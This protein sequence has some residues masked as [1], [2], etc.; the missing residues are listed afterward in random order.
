M[1][2]TKKISRHNYYALLWHALFLALAKN[3]MDVDTIIPAMMID[4]GGT[5][6]HIGLL[7]AIMLGGSHLSQLFFAPFIN[8]R[9]MKKGCLLLGINA[10]IFA[11]TCLAFLFFLSSWITGSFLIIM[12]FLFISVFSTSGGFAN[13]GYTDIL[14]KS[15]LPESRKAFFSVKQV[16]VSTGLFASAYFASRALTLN[17]YPN[18]YA[19]LFVIATVMLTIASAGFWRLKEIKISKHEI[20]EYKNFILVILHEIRS[21]KKLAYYLLVTNTQGVSLA[22]MP[23]LILYAKDVLNATGS[24]IGNYLIFKVIGGILVG[25]LLFY[26]SRKVKYQ[27]LLYLT[28]MLAFIIPLFVLILPGHFSLNLSFLAGGI[29]FTLHTIAVSGVLLEVSTNENR[30]LYTGIVGAGSVL[31]VVFPLAS[32][33]VIN[34]FG[35]SMFFIL[36]MF[37]IS[38]SFYFIFKLDCQA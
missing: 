11:L 31:P 8:N 7:T 32:S 17:P 22:L 3:F 14:G 34:Q 35:F 20:Y 36:F 9:P 21:N 5:S 37:I 12:I 25:A 29:V 4:A 2:L 23:F 19:F 33:W 15:V 27:H 10:R 26:H 24:D 30:V 6:V 18:N 1:N 28:S 16:I 38:F 13:I